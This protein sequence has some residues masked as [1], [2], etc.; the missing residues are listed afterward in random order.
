MSLVIL[1]LDSE[2]SVARGAAEIDE[3]VYFHLTTRIVVVARGGCGPPRSPCLD[4][5]LL[6]GRSSMRLTQALAA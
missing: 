3:H 4:R 2:L 1:A 5:R 6:T